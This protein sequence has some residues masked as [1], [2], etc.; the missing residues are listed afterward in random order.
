LREDHPP[1][2]STFEDLSSRE[3]RATLLLAPT[4]DA[5]RKLRRTSLAAASRRAGRTRY[6]DRDVE[7][8]LAGLRTEQLRQPELVEK[9]MAVQA[10]AYARAHGCGGGDMGEDITHRPVRHLAE[11][12]SSQPIGHAQG[13]HC[14]ATAATIVG[15]E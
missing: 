3:A 6:V 10:S 12:S 4:P 5:A 11:A 14:P 9:A 8:I 13:R 2:L 7:K 15:H 1:F